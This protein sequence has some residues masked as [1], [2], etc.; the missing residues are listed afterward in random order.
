MSINHVS[1]SY[2]HLGLLTVATL[3]CL[4]SLPPRSLRKKGI[5]CR[6]NLPADME[7]WRN[8]E[9][10][11]Y[12]VTWDELRPLLE[13]HGFRLWRRGP[14]YQAQDGAHTPC[15]NFLFLTTDKIRNISLVRWNSFLSLN[16]LSH[17]AR[18]VNAKRDVILR[19]LT[20]G[21]QGQ[22]HLRI[23][24]RLSSPPDILMS[25]NHILPLIHE[26]VYQDIVI[27][28]F[29]KLV[30]NL[31]ESLDADKANTVEDILHMV[32]QAFE[33]VAYLHRNLIGHRKDLFLNNIM[34][35]W[36]PTSLQVRTMTRPRVYI[37]DFETAV[38]FAEDSANSERLC[39]EHPFGPE[40]YGRQIAPELNGEIQPYCPF[41]L[42]MWQLGSNLNNHFR[43]G[44]LELDQFWS[45]M[46]APAP[47]DRTTA[48]D[49][50][51]FLDGYL[52][53]TPPSELHRPIPY[54]IRP[55]QQFKQ[56]H[57]TPA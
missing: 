33:G 39:L 16:G 42:D 41:K 46:A 13:Q 25:N 26:I 55:M 49:A 7:K 1:Y 54:I 52:R 6:S 32:V 8:V 5:T 2:V 44:T 36:M 53:R 50:L 10:E 48:D 15:D 21:G 4:L 20:A 27:L 3:A 31:H 38:D 14:G 51:A 57:F 22:A 24:R 9:D 12:D 40:D 28:A 34:V 56:S 19:V 47:K 17:A 23:I 43:T 29:P 11:E 35:E 37:I 30:V 45:C 18:S